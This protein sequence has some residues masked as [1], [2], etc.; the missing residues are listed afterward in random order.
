MNLRKQRLLMFVLAVVLIGLAGWFGY[1]A[2]L[3]YAQRTQ[4]KA[5]IKQ[6]QIA[7]ASHRYL[8]EVDRE[9]YDSALFANQQQET[10]SLK[11]QRQK[12]DAAYDA[13]TQVSDKQAAMADAL[14][15]IPKNIGIVRAQVDALSPDAKGIWVEGYGGIAKVLSGA[16]ASLSRHSAVGANGAQLSVLGELERAYGAASVE[17]NFLIYGAKH[18]KMMSGEGLRLWEE[19]LSNDTFD[20][21]K[22]MED[23]ALRQKLGGVLNF[24]D[25]D[26]ALQQM[27]TTVIGQLASLDMPFD[28][29]QWHKVYTQ[30][31]NRYDQA[32]REIFAQYRA[33]SLSQLQSIQKQFTINISLAVLMLVLLVTLLWASRYVRRENLLLEE[34]LRDI[35]LDLDNAKKAELLRVIEKGDAQGTYAFLANTIRESS[36]TKD[37]FLA[38]MSHEIRTP[39]NGIMGFT[40]LLKTATS[41]AER[42]EYVHVIE[43]SS[44][45]LLSIVNDILDLSKIKA[46]KVELENIPFDPIGK[47]ESA[48]EAMGA[49]ALLK[50][51]EFGVYVDPR[52]PKGIMG[53]PT[54]L[55]Q[56][57]VNLI[58]NAIKFTPDHGHIGLSCEQVSVDTNEVVIRFSVQDTGIGISEEQQEKIFE[59]FAQ[60]DISTT[61]QYGGTGLGLSISSKLVSLMGGKLEL[62]SVVGKGSMFYFTL[63]FPLET[64]AEAREN[65]H[66]SGLRAGV[67]LPKRGIDRFV[68]TI[69][70]QFLEHMGVEG[71]LYYADEMDTLTE[72]H[73]PDILF[74]D[75]R[76]SQ[77]ERELEKILGYKTRI[78]LVAGGNTSEQ[79]SLVR[80]RLQ[81]V[82]YK[83]INY[84]KIE[85]TLA[86]YVEGK[87]SEIVHTAQRI[88]R[89]DGVKILVA[90]DNPINQKL[91]RVT[92]DN[93]GLDVTLVSNG[94]EAVAARIKGEYN[95]I[96]MDIQ[97]PVMNGMEATKAILEYE[98]RHHLEHIPI[99]ALTAN[100]L[101]GD[102]EKYLDVGMD[103]YVPKPLQ[104]EAI[105]DIIR[106]YCPD[107]ERL[108]ESSATVEEESV[109][110]ETTMQS[111]IQKQ[112]PAQEVVLYISNSLTR[113]IHEH[114]LKPI[115]ECTFV[116]NETELVEVLE[117]KENA[118][119]AI[120]SVLLPRDHCYFADLFDNHH[121]KKIY[122]FGEKE[123][124][125]C[126]ALSVYA[127]IR[128]LRD[129]LKNAA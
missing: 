58:G 124:I 44:H 107:R 125:E 89:F 19:I 75:Q 4:N 62:D 108:V 36:R 71:T 114:L 1:Q 38:N 127:A 8:I 7:E 5:H 101:K 34:T 28:A 24:S 56:V 60:A 72:E 110:H 117:N 105:R 84:S 95:L 40:Q 68:D 55:S 66:Y 3:L 99:I 102:R 122:V 120:D 115:A 48:A 46:G 86:R 27:R 53:D 25:L 79:I 64:E 97:M 128:E 35:E 26:K 12:T 74:V 67:L 91:I 37:L 83:P 17:K 11:K 51:I 31:L 65:P 90:E 126:S 129:I 88:S 112:P 16:I 13:L 18:P 23:T 77:R 70:L 33:H 111:D 2:S 14:A 119:I 113:S 20:G 76:Y 43:E 42:E 104:I 21:I 121:V 45:M 15:Q 82:I 96:F 98:H 9:G 6:I 29:K 118:I 116:E 69:L 41:D 63:S 94:E 103:D 93:F 61:R 123:R 87:T 32:V 100:V 78:V 109:E 52:L 54:R 22:K 50:N 30:K 57:L 85:R 47:I 81:D 80:E 106:H 92:L 39:L 10:A 49:K 73:L 59:A